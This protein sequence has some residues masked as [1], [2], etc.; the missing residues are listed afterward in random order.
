MKEWESIKDRLKISSP[1]LHQDKS[2][3]D[4]EDLSNHSTCLPKTY[5]SL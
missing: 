4:T 2:D 5:Y 3:N 1:S